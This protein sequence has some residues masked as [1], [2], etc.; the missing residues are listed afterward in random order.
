VLSPFAN[1]HFL[2]SS[3][4]NPYIK[5]IKCPPELSR[6]TISRASLITRFKNELS[7]FSE[8]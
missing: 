7:L 6:A 4:L 2:K 1:P 8:S 5:F 3:G